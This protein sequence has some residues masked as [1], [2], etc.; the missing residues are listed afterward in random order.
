MEVAMAAEERINTWVCYYGNTLGPERYAPFDMAVLDGLNPPP[1]IRSDGKPMYLGYVSIG[2]V[3]GS[4]PYWELARGRR[5]LAGENKAWNS[6][7]VDIRDPQWQSIL[8]NEILPAVAAKGFDGFF[9]DTIDSALHLA[10][11][12]EGEKFAG[13]EQAAVALIGKMR[14]RYPDKRIAVNRGLR[15]LPVLARNIDFV[16][17][18]NLY[19]YYDGKDEIHRRVDTE[20]QR[21][22]LQQVRAGLA[23]KPALTVLTIDY[24]SP[25]DKAL[26]DE[27]IAFSREKGFIPYVGNHLLDAIYE[28]TLAK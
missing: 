4:G 13:V 8:L 15:I 23:I 3:H 22:L 7:I 26:A 11:G 24:A 14:K 5:F 25:R 20:T 16:I 6:W 9:L 28:F 19:S 10:E 27:A 1:L 12:K 21:I 2:E 18:E 17:I